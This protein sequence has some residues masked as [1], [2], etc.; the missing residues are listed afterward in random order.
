M[1]MDKAGRIRIGRE[2]LGLVAQGKSWREVA[3][4]VGQPVS[5][6]RRWSKK[7]AE[8]DGAPG[9]A[10][11]TEPGHETPQAARH[12]R[13]ATIVALRIQRQPV[14]RELIQDV[15][16]PHLMLPKVVIRL[17]AQMRREGRPMSDAWEVA[18]EFVQRRFA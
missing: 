9:P 18:H 11:P 12:R 8:L 3:R 16:I 4:E 13:I 14:P 2:V 15:S 5:N 10:A 17:R 1:T 6:C 7:A